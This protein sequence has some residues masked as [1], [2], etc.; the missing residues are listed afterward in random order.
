MARLP[1][2][3]LPHLWIVGLAVVALPGLG[4]AQPRA[5]D[6]D[7]ECLVDVARSKGRLADADKR[8]ADLAMMYYLGRLTTRMSETE[9]AERIAQLP[10]PTTEEQATAIRRRCAADLLTAAIFL[11]PINKALSEAAK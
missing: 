8:R 2:P 5:S 11:A 7:L 4:A 3:A 1:F 10:R 6:P 9:V